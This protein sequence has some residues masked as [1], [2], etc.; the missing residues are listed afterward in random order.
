MS[1]QILLSGGDKWYSYSG[2]V[3]G[4]VSVP[5]SISMILISNTGLRDSYIEIQP[6]FGQEVTSGVD[7]ALGI[8]VLID[9]VAMFTSQSRQQQQ[10]RETIT[11]IIKIFVPRQSKLEI[12]SLNT[13][14]NNTQERGVNL[15]GYYL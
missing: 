1:S 10:E 5:A 11:N 8:N 3:F 4:D 14:N 2:I 6:Y 12:I 13:T 15:I 9:D 7:E